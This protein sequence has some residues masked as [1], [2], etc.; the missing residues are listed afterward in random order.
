MEAAHILERGIVSKCSTPEIT[1]LESR[2]QPVM[3]EGKGCR[4]RRWGVRELGVRNS[5]CDQI[6]TKCC[7]MGNMLP[8]P[9]PHNLQQF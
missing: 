6:N 4:E 9:Q 8:M 3:V 2:I 1:H 7:G 5:N